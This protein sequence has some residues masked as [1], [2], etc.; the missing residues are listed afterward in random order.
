M[1]LSSVEQAEQVRD[2][3]NLLNGLESDINS[4]SMNMASRYRSTMEAMGVID[5]KLLFDVATE[6]ELTDRVKAVDL[7]I[8]KLYEDGVQSTPR[9]EVDPNLP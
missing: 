5:T 7:V 6:V 2:Y 8:T 9:A 4:H 3:I 1:A